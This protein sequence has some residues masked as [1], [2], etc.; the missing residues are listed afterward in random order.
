MVTILLCLIV[1]YLL[2]QLVALGILLRQP[3]NAAKATAELPRLSIWVAA[4][5]EA[6]QIGDCLESLSQ[7]DYPSGQLEILV[8]NDHSTDDTAAVVS[9]F[10]EGKPQFRLVEI[11]ENLG[12]A[13]GKANVLAHLAHRSSGTVFAIADADVRVS[14]SWARE[15]VR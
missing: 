5:N 13:R 15:L 1:L 7:L 8:G 2:I 3:H 12:K 4:R 11:G 9:R 14:P 6:H 10:I